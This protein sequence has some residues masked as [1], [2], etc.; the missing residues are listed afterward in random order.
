M[1]QRMSGVALS[2]LLIMVRLVITLLFTPFLVASLGTE[3]YGLFALAGAMAAYLYI[4]DFG[5]NDS[6][7]RF[8]VTHERDH[9]AR[10]GFLGRMLG[11]YAGLGLAVLLLA[12]AFSALAGPVF[13]GSNTPGQVALLRSMIVINGAGAAVLIAFNPFGALLSAAERFVFLRGLEIAS[14]IVAMLVL[15]AVLRAG[16]GPVEVVAVTAGFTAL[17]ALL[18]PVY[19]VL[20]LRVRLRIGLPDLRELRRVGGYAA[21]IFASMIAGVIFWKFD[22]ILIGVMLGAASV[23]VYAIGVTFNKYFMSFATAISRIM[24]PEIVRRIDAGADAETLTDLMIRISRAQA[25][26]LLMILGGL[27]V[28]GERFLVLWLGAEFAASYAV[29]VLVLVPYALEM[30]GNARNIVLQVKGL[31]WHKSAITL[32]MAALNIPLTVVLLQIWGVAG[33]AA[34]TGLAVIAGYLAVAALLQRRVGIRMGRYWRETGRGIVPVFAAMVAAGLLGA[35]HL[36]D[37]WGGLMAGSGLFA[38]VYVAAMLGL[39][40][41]AAER[42]MVRRAVTGALSRRRWRT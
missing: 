38:T 29:L 1:S 17:Q 19:A 39:A 23:A 26:V 35:R 24:T 21:P 4:L 30:T 5:M 13:G 3:G 15:V 7:L 18:R 36:P 11:L 28:F 33:A 8:F 14:T 34:S 42:G 12:L 27:I 37:G 31:Y 6:V 2:Y 25:L 10:D 20:H 32:G 16:Y 40:A 22:S 9:A 41:T